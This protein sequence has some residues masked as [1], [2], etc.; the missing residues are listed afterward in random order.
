MGFIACPIWNVK[1]TLSFRRSH[2]LPAKR[3]RLVA[4]E[5]RR[6]DPESVLLAGSDNLIA[7]LKI[8]Q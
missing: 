7:Q 3:L 1:V 8:I 2:H 6:A 4:V 5:Q